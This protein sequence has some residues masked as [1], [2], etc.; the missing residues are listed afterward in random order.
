MDQKQ[1]AVDCCVILHCESV[2][3]D[4][5]E[6]RSYSLAFVD[7]FQRTPELVVFGAGRV[8]AEYNQKFTQGLAGTWWRSLVTQNRYMHRRCAFSHAKRQDFYKRH[9]VHLHRPD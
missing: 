4:A 7:Y 9:K 3:A 5:E 2:A 8:R 6:H 1:L